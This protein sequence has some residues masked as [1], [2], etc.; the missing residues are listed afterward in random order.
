MAK[1]LILLQMDSQWP[2]PE[3]MRGGRIS[4]REVALEFGAVNRF[5]SLFA[6]FAARLREM[7]RS[8][9]KHQLVAI[10]YGIGHGLYIP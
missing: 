3:K 1:R 6:H 2:I 7:T 4:F 9:L 10:I 5:G 8:V